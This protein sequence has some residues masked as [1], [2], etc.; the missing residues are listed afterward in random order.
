[1]E[2]YSDLGS[3]QVMDTVLIFPV[4]KYSITCMHQMYICKKYNIYKHLSIVTTHNFSLSLF[5]TSEMKTT[6][7]FDNFIDDA[8]GDGCTLDI[9]NEKSTRTKTNE[10]T[11]TTLNS[12]EYYCLKFK[13]WTLIHFF[14]MS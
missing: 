6:V 12:K 3:F 8:L 5:L 14:V 9:M 2:K 11:E 4:F 1:M 10:I 7:V 13:L